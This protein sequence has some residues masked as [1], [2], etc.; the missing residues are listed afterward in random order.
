MNEGKDNRVDSRDS[1]FQNWTIKM[2]IGL[3]GVI[4]A[5]LWAG[6]NAYTQ[7]HDNKKDIGTTK[8]RMDTKHDRQQQEIDQLYEIIH[9]LECE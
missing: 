3:L 4:V 1:N 2:P 5:G 9:K 8:R 6:F 7:I